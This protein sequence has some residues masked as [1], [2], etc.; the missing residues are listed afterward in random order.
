[1]GGG[2]IV[3]PEDKTEAAVCHSAPGSELC[4]YPEDH[5]HSFKASRA[6]VLVSCC[7]RLDSRQAGQPLNE[8][9][10]TR[11]FLGNPVATLEGLVLM[12]DRVRPSWVTEVQLLALSTAGCPGSAVPTERAGLCV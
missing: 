10:A 5:C 7:R 6:E 2:R 9:A 8:D 11:S 4:P 1:M 12:R 3:Y